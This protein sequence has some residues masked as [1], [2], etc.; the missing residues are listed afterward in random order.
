M[1]ENIKITNFKPKIKR[2]PV[3]LKAKL[4]QLIVK[5]NLTDKTKCELILKLVDMK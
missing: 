5:S 2:E 4:G 1:E 3:N